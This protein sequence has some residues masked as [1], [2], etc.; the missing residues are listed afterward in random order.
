MSKARR[1][2]KMAKRRAEVLRRVRG[3]APCTLTM[4]SVRIGDTV[5]IYG[6]TKYAPKINLGELPSD[7]FDPNKSQCVKIEYQVI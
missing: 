1:V 5:I 3:E 7:V 2:K 4:N 6:S